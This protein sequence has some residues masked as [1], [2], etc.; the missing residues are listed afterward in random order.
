MRP[1]SSKR[2]KWR[3]LWLGK[4]TAANSFGWAPGG[5]FAVAPMRHCLAACLLTVS[6]RLAKQFCGHNGPAATSL[7]CAHR[8]TGPQQAFAPRTVST[9]FALCPFLPLRRVQCLTTGQ[10]SIGHQENNKQSHWKEFL[11][12]S[13]LYLF[14][15]NFSRPFDLFETISK[16]SLRA[17][18][19]RFGFHF[20]PF[21]VE[22]YCLVRR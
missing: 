16:R 17:P 2:G 9:N 14:S 1:E 7:N 22:I 13:S 18:H 4:Q 5:Q 12:S 19:F 15:T 8:P 6:G 3:D 21:Q 20:F 11:F 10:I